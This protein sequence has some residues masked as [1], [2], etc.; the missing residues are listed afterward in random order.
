MNIYKKTRD[1]LPE[2]PNACPMP[3]ASCPGPFRTVT[4]YSNFVTVRNYRQLSSGRILM[5]SFLFLQVQDLLR[6]RRATATAP[7]PSALLL[8]RARP[9]AVDAHSNPSGPSFRYWLLSVALELFFATRP[10]RLGSPVCLSLSLEV[11]LVFE[12]QQI[13]GSLGGDC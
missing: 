11:L 2:A 12:E 9:Y 5:R 1:D 6:S 8:A 10:E 7:L 4:S 13:E 3:S